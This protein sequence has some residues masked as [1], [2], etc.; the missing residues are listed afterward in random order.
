MKKNLFLMT[1]LFT[2]A[3]VSQTQSITPNTNTEF[4][5]N[6]DITFSVSIPGSD[7]SIASWTN[8]PIISLG[9]YDK[10]TAGGVTTFKFKGRFQD[11]NVNQV[12]KISYRDG[13][14][15]DAIYYP[16]FKKIKS[17]HFD[18]TSSPT[19]CFPIQPNQTAISAPLC[20]ISN[21]AVS[22]DNIKWSTY[23]ENPVYCFGTITTYPDL[24]FLVLRVSF[25]RMSKFQ[26]PE[27]NPSRI[28]W[29]KNFYFGN[30]LLDSKG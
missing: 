3:K 24:S 21:L 25:K 22:F 12:Y 6:I 13:N 20:Q 26:I 1:I 4:C 17:L 11:V 23:G 28:V 27:L 30:C 16:S 29:I 8:S 9:I 14:G 7:P 19:S 15:E 2:L 5:P 10:T 18:N